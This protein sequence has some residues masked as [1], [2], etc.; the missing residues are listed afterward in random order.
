MPEIWL[1]YGD[2]EIILDMKYENI[3]QILKTNFN[4]IEEKNIFEL[5][6]KNLKGNGKSLILIFRPFYQILP[7]LNY[8]KKVNNE[9]IS[10]KFEINIVD[11]I[12]TSNIRKRL[13]DRGIFIERINRKN[14][15]QKIKDFE[16][17]YI[18]SSIS[19]NPVFGYDC[20]CTDL[21]KECF[22]E[23]MDH[24]YSKYIINSLPK[25]GIINEPLKISM[26][27]SKTKSI[28]FIHVICNKENIQSILFEEMD[29]SFLKA[30]DQF[31]NLTQIYSDTSKALILSGKS[32]L[33]IQDT[34]GDSLNIL[35][36]NI[37]MVREKGTIIL[38]SE[39]KNGIGTGA[40][41]QFIESR[42]DQ[43]SLD[44]YKYI[45]D[46]EHINFLN[47]LK[48]KFEIYCISTLPK[49][50]I[51]KFGI[52]SIDGI[53]K[54]K[55]KILSNYGKYAKVLIIED[56]DLIHGINYSTQR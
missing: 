35:W 12:L 44:K 55:D 34:L 50:Y 8:F 5:L 22:A 41:L 32:S 21:L 47:L 40:L 56:S 11:R 33:N 18:L 36:N 42:L 27:I 30:L 25:P 1:G 16:N 52:Q 46:I 17:V 2:S 4:N 19:Y 20:G 23:E 29:K 43:E 45:K 31:N 15:I 39:S 10:R 49:T 53:N 24:I 51:N 9:S 37:L 3:L 48:E 14:V 38:L 28:N 7:F 26:E 13:T 6:D 54:A